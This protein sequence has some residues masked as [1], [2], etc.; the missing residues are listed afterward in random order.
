[1]T[2][3]PIVHDTLAVLVPREY[4]SS[5]SV[6]PTRVA[7]QSFVLTSVTLPLIAD[8]H[9]TA[10][11]LLWHTAMSSFSRP[12]CTSH[13]CFDENVRYLTPWSSVHPS[14]PTYAVVVCDVVGVDVC[15]VVADVVRVVVGVVV[16]VSVVVAVVVDVAVVV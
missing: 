10:P 1:M 12:T 7:A 16:V 6:K 5:T 3:S 4:L 8:P 11:L 13:A 2:V 15:V 9:A 14:R